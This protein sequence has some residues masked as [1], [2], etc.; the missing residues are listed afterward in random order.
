MLP[1]RG[2]LRSWARQRAKSALKSHAKI[3][4]PHENPQTKVCTKNPH[5]KSHK[6]C[7]QKSE[8]KKYPHGI[9]MLRE[10]FLPTSPKAR[11]DHDPRWGH[12]MGTKAN[13]NTPSLDRK[14]VRLMFSGALFTHPQEESTWTEKIFLRFRENPLS[15]NRFEKKTVLGQSRQNVCCSLVFSLPDKRK[16]TFSRNVG[17]LPTA[18]LAAKCENIG[19]TGLIL[20]I[21]ATVPRYG[22][23]GRGMTP[24][25]PLKSLATS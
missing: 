21:G 22:G 14:H 18:A 8:Y 23:A 1:E 9:G 13:W 17:V 12:E 15:R 10:A 25:C 3:L 6:I 16:S 4:N 20:A 5:K 24:I 2:T 11:L 7:T 19:A